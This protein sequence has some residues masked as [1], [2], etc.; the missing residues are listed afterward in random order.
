MEVQ[1]E[2][3]GSEEGELTSS[4][5]VGLRGQSMGVESVMMIITVAPLLLSGSEVG[6]VSIPTL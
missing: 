4:W 2:L 1:I 3:W 6:S 5:G